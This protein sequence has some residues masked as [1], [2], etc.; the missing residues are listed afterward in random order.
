MTVSQLK[1]QRKRK[2]QCH[3]LIGKWRLILLH[4]TFSDC[5]LSSALRASTYAGLFDILFFIF[6]K[7]N[8]ICKAKPW[9]LC[10]HS[11][12]GWSACKT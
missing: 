4:V 1:S 9:F 2:I 12:S 11:Q 5:E 8:D 3:S 6:L 10:L 7:S